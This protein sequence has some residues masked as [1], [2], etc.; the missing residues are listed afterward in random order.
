MK[1]V[2]LINFLE[3]DGSEM[4]ICA[5]L[6]STPTAASPSL[7]DGGITAGPH[8]QPPG[9]KLASSLHLLVVLVSITMLRDM[10]QDTR[11]SSWIL[12]LQPVDT[13]STSGTWGIA[14][15]CYCIVK[16]PPP[17]CACICFLYK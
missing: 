15:G 17:V 9:T 8:M 5:F 11:A 14:L 10:H 13:H 7:V 1:I 3:D 4:A 12:L 2:V 6:L 16:L